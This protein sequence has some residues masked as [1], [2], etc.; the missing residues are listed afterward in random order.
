MTFKA[1]SDDVGRLERKT[2]ALLEHLQ[3]L[4]PLAVAVSGGVDSSFL[5]AA[6]VK[7]TPD[8]L[9][10]LGVSPTL[11]KAA[12]ERAHRLAG[13]LGV[14]V[15]EVETHELEDAAYVANGPDRCYFCKKELFSVL[16]SLDAVV[17]GDEAGAGRTL[18][19]GTQD[20][21]RGDA[22][23]GRRAAREL[24]VASPLLDL[25]WTK[26]EIRAVSR[27]WGLETWNLPSGPCLSSRIP[28]GIAVTPQA[29]Q[30]IEA[31][32]TALRELGFLEVRVRDHGSL[33]RV[34]LPS[35]DLPR[36]LELRAEIAEHLEAAG[37]YEVTLDL[38]G[39]RPAGSSLRTRMSGA[40][41][42]TSAEPMDRSEV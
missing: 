5:L 22:R 19:D 3:G 23:P 35:T 1:G 20:D 24:G 18:L 39:Y 30:R 2:H 12:R 17:R 25:G 6:A 14:A 7:A 4:E 10:L 33:A 29:L 42:T 38:R 37:Y 9:A 16:Q 32:E 27:Q 15:R 8:V 31:G 13:A 28:T 40:N 34:E 41:G 36:A 21:D 26:E 11:P